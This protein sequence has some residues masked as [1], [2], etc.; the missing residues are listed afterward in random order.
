MMRK[1]SGSTGLS[2]AIVNSF[3]DAIISK[4]LDGTVTSWNAAAS[5]L[6]GYNSEEMIGEPI[7]RLI[8]TERQV[9]EDRILAKIEDGERLESY[10]TVRLDKY[11]RRIDVFLTISPIRNQDR[12]IIGASEIIR[13]IASP[14]DVSESSRESDERLRQFVEQ[15]PVAI[16][17]L[18]R[19]MVQLACSRRWLENNQVDD[20]V[21]IIGRCHY[22]VF[23]DIPERW[24]EVHRREVWLARSCGQTKKS[25]SALMGAYSGGA[26]KCARG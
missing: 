19:N 5:A 6:F 26:G 4:T 10:T 18:D 22:E 21:D 8:P 15:A 25:S 24:K 17:M 12:K 23:P 20:G 16:M 7:R 2:A 13:T 9:E 1:N 14:K 11:E 3:F